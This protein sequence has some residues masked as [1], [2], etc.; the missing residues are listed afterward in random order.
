MRLDYAISLW[1]YVHFASTAPLEQ[2]LR[3]I[4]ELGYGVE[5][6]GEWRDGTD[7]YDQGARAWLKPLLEGMAVSLHTVISNNLRQHR[8]QID[9]AADLGAGVVVIHADDLYAGAS[10]TLDVGL[11]REVVA[12]AAERDVQI[13]LENGQLPFLTNA[14]RAVDG[15]KIC[16][17]FGHVYLTQ[18][19]LA[20]FLDALGEHIIHLHLHDILLP[21]EEGLAGVDHW[22]PGTGG[23]PLAD[24]HL[25]MAKL[26]AI[27]FQGMAIFEIRPRNPLQTAQLGVRFMQEL[28]DRQP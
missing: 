24:W 12:Y 26:Q 8:K 16:L 25:L 5:L 22:E 2:E 10:K 27:D 4:A 17:D 21:I 7:L 13:A 1:N 14:L 18:D 19:P 15:L 23:I 11:A 6:W 9:A 20:A 28:W 3:R